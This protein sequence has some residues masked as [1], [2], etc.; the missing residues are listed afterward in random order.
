MQAE[1][2]STP[3]TG[4][5]VMQRRR[6]A[7]Y[8]LAAALARPDTGPGD[9]AELRRLDERSPDRAGYWKLLM[10]WVPEEE[11]RTPADEQRWAVI[12]K[13]MALMTTGAART[14]HAEGARPGRVLAG[15]HFSELRLNRLLRLRGAALNEAF[16]RVCRFLAAKGG[17]VDWTDFGQLVLAHTEQAGESQRRRIA[18]DYYGALEQPDQSQAQ[19][20]S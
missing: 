15:H 19:W 3:T 8:A 11:R 18:R 1:A 2:E 9:L 17:P 12:M 13:G 4:Q 20:Q 16:L 14:H 10:R 5:D 7:L 6:R